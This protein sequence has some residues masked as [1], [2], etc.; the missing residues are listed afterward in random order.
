M[1][2]E[3]PVKP[4]PKENIFNIHPA[5]V[6]S[7]VENLPMGSTGETSKQLYYAI[8]QVNKQKNSAVKQLEFLETLAPTIST[9]YP[10]LEK[11]F[12]DVSL[13]L[14]TKTRNAIH[15]TSSLLTE[16]LLSYKSIIKNLFTSKSFGWKKP[17]ILATHR[18]TIYSSQLFYA[19]QLIYQPVNKGSWRDV[20]WCYQ[21]AEKLNLLHKSF[22]N[23]S[24][25]KEKT[26]V[27]YEFKNLALLSLLNINDLGYKNRQHVLALMPLWIKHCEVLDN[28]SDDKKT[29]FVLN[30]LSDNPPYLIQTRG[31]SENPKTDY[32]Y[33]TTFKL[34]KV[35]EGYQAKMKDAESIQIGKQTLSRST[36]QSLLTYWSREQLRKEPR[37]TGTGFVDI[38][39]G[40][41][42]IHFVLNKQDQPAY[43]NILTDSPKVVDFESTLTIEPLQHKPSNGSLG[44]DYFLGNS[45]QEQD[46]WNKVYE[47]SIN[48]PIQK[49]NWTDTGNHK[50]YSHTK[51]ILLDYSKDGYRLSVN[52]KNI[53]GLK[54]NELVAVREHALAPW[55]LAQV[56]WIHF[57]QIGD[58]Q[59]GLRILTHHVLP[60]NVRFEAN[61]AMSK[62]LPCL[63]GLD[64]KKLLLFVPTLPTNLNGKKLQIA[65]Q[66]Q[67]SSIRLNNRLLST[68]AF[69]VYEIHEPA[70]KE[71][72]KF[73]SI[74]ASEI[75]NTEDQS[76]AVLSDNIWNNF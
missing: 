7:W 4:T 39:S 46:V 25:N 35:L 16:L 71:H 47:N 65:H 36:I 66:D 62:P 5:A 26:S 50:I 19:Q 15:V 76:H 9:I 33:L 54:Q 61:Q 43:T 68:P 20:Y 40:I 45:E 56:K 18:L 58:L 27:L 41:T 63:I 14:D 73:Q 75:I 42:A 49:A 48:E 10:R 31:D 52:E 1:T 57:S 67:L 8:R 53:D 44:L 74:N 59:F 32:H 72:Q 51:S 29:C 6:K 55:A 3:Q 34:K 64:T 2:T 60:V 37:K 11:Y 22:Y 30:L 69:D 23:Y 17:F 28:V 24:L 70:V 12:S 21:Q 38:I 13:P